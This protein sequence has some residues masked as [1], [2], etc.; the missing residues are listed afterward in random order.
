MNAPVFIL[1]T[2]GPATYRGKYPARVRSV[3]GGATGL[4]VELNDGTRLWTAKGAD[5]FADLPRVNTDLAAFRAKALP[6]TAE[7]YA[8]LRE[9]ADL[10]RTRAQIAGHGRRAELEARVRA[11]V[12]AIQP[13]D[14]A[15]AKRNAEARR[16]EIL[17]ETSARLAF[18]P[19]KPFRVYN[20]GPWGSTCFDFPTADEA[21]AYL[22]AQ[23]ERRRFAT[24]GA[25]PAGPHGDS[26][27]PLQSFIVSPDGTETLADLGWTPPAEGDRL[28]NRPAPALTDET[29]GG[30]S[31]AID[32]LAE[33][34]AVRLVQTRGPDGESRLVRRDNVEY[35]AGKAAFA[36]GEAQEDC[37]YCAGGERAA[38]WN[39][40]WREAAKAADEREAA[41]ADER[42]AKVS[43]DAARALG[44][45]SCACNLDRSANPFPA[46]S[47]AGEAWDSGY[48]E[49]MADW[50][51]ERRAEIADR[52][53]DEAADH[54]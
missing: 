8:A 25:A 6:M 46:D 40:G 12:S 31:A 48:S 5:H 37:P 17:A 26:I 14:S 47:A 53:G 21:R 20:R 33:R 13:D 34:A 38:R 9:A 10:L 45:Q 30:A 24:S 41:E 15:Y 49:A 16:A 7:Q 35:H 18:D 28:W 29:P 22:S 32:G 4:H 42:A 11:M 3:S 54:F 52:Y 27:D 1:P 19:A 51:A 43:P 23:A 2:S 44:A 39:L 50:R 36:A